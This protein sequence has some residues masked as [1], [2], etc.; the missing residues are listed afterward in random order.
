MA[1]LTGTPGPE[2]LS[3]GDET[4]V[5][6][7]GGG[8]DTLLGGG[9]FDFYVFAPG[10]GRDV[11][12]EGVG[13][14][15]GALQFEAGV[16]ASDVRF[17]R[18]PDSLGEPS[19]DLRVILGDDWVVIEDFFT[20]ETDF[21]FSAGRIDRIEFASGAAITL[22]D[23]IAFAGGDGDDLVFGSGRSERLLGGRGDDTLSGA[24]GFDV[25]LFEDDSGSDVIVERE[26]QDG[27]AIRFGKNI[28]RQYTTLSRPPNS[29]TE[30][31]RDLVIRF[32]ANEI[33]VE[34]FFQD[35]TD[36]ADATGKLDRIDFADGQVL[37]LTVPLTFE[38]GVGA[39]TLLGGAA[40]ETLIGGRGDDLLE[41]GGGFDIYEFDAGFGYDRIIEY[42]GAEGGAI[43]FGRSVSPEAVRLIR[44][45]DGA[46]ATARDLVVEVAGDRITV[47]DFYNGR[48]DFAVPQGRIG[49][50]EFASGERLDLTGAAALSGGPAPDRI[51]GT[52][53][54]D[55]LV[56]G[57]GDDTLEGGGDIDLYVFERGFGDDRIVDYPDE[58]GAVIR[59][60]AGVAREDLAIARAADAPRTAVISVGED[61]I[62]I[63]EFY[64]SNDGD[65]ATGKVARIEIVES[66]PHADLGPI[67]VTEMFD[68]VN[69]RDDVLVVENGRPTTLFPLV[70]DEAPLGPGSLAV[71]TVGRAD[72]GRVRL[73]P[74]GAV[75]YEPPAGYVGPAQ[76]SYEAGDGATG[77]DAAFVF[78]DVVASPAA[79]VFTG[80]AGPD[81]LAGGEVDDVLSG[82][83]GA[84]RLSGGAGDDALVGGPGDDSLF[85]G[86]GDDRLEGGDGDDVLDG[87]GGADTLAG[88][89]GHDTATF[90]G[91]GR[92]VGARLD[93]GAGFGGAAG[94][95][96]SGVE[97]L[98]GSDFDDALIGSALADRIAGGRGADRILGLE[99]DDVLAGG[100]DA[101]ALDGGPGFDMADY[102]GSSGPVG[103]RLDG[104]VNFGAA[105]GDRFTAI[106]GLSGG[107]FDDTLIGSASNNR[108]SGAAGSDRLFGLAGDDTLE[109]G[110]GADALNGGA[111]VDVADYASATQA[112]GARLD[113]GAGW[114]GAAGDAFSAIE[115]LSGSRFDDALIGDGAAN[116]LS[117]GAGE[118]RLFGLDGAD[119]LIGGAGADLLDGGAGRDAASYAA[120]AGAVGA[121][122]DLGSAWGA[123]AGDMLISIETLIGSAFGDG[124]IG[125]SERN[126]LSGGDGSDRL[127]GL[128]GE[129]A[130]FGG[131]GD[132]TLDG[133]PGADALDGGPGV[134]IAEYGSETRAVGVRLDRGAAWGGAEGDALSAIEGLAGSAFADT[135]IG[136]AAANTLEGRGGVDR[137]WGLGGRDRFLFRGPGFG[138]DIIQDFE[139]GVDLLDFSRYA[140][141]DA[142]ADL[143][144]A[145]S[146]TSV[147]IGVGA[148][149][150]FLV[151]AVL[152]EISAAAFDFA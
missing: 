52:G 107:A 129:D 87:G 65:A 118:D 130:L 11:I 136:D 151:D 17:F 64:R 134:D 97:V 105:A 30:S 50:I 68:R 56:G 88:G 49:R 139:Q 83:A 78:L 16:D 106:E 86:A 42:D 141:I 2:T 41:G 76:F 132:D 32:G 39:D 31:A 40:A 122:L 36:F 45:R 102:A 77:S 82:F 29:E 9:G 145:Q 28:H 140:A 63:D 61:T 148:D 51:S 44:P 152:A 150:I 79:P 127:L 111:G 58:N 89:A 114:G 69:A 73:D 96:I 6:A 20:D 124:L 13:A 80:G 59:F 12:S 143:A 110:A 120:A 66:G 14:D 27:G 149:T 92:G 137:L 53:F 128:A 115:G 15:G 18:E 70:N 7:G 47:E 135:L 46:D 117:G 99:G 75:V 67:P 84:D 4:D 72:E 54:A 142:L 112:V 85:G 123:A 43:R 71:L 5:L 62:R 34:S 103:A 25:Y 95:R 35:G 60:G 55:T 131:A 138:V 24:G 8:N 38:G 108:L 104:G 48:N 93:G 90:A 144:I 91:L 98:I 74:H 3:G 125:S 19:L 81:I 133:G 146:G 10:F 119:T 23:P 21:S 22:S 1:R 37:D 101:D 109:G 121:R 147:R 116:A 33:L 57:S 94:V 126:L 100:A 113:L 26:S